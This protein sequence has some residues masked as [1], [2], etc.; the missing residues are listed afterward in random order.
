MMNR[1]AICIAALLGLSLLTATVIRA[2][3]EF[4]PK[5]DFKGSR[6]A[7]G[8]LDAEPDAASYSDSTFGVPEVKFRLNYQVAPDAKMTFRANLNNGIFSDVDY[9]YL[10]YSNALAKL[11]PSLKGSA[12]NPNIRLG[13]IKLDIGEETWGNNMVEAATI[14]PSSTNTGAYDEAIQFFQSLPK[15]KLGIPVKWS[16]SVSNGNS[17]SGT[18]NKNDK[19][20]CM[21]LGANPIKELYV[22]ASYYNSGELG[23][24][25][26]AMSYAGLTARPTNSTEWRRIITEIDLR[27]DIQPGKENRLEPTGPAFSDSKAFF[28]VAYGQFKDDGKDTV[29]PIL[30]VTDREGTYYFIDATYNATDKIYVAGRYSQVGFNKDTLLASLNKVT[31]NQFTRITTDIGYRMSDNTH[32]KAEYMTNSEDVAAGVTEPGN[33]QYSVILAVKF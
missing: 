10:D 8:Y 9:A 22:S 20:F 26:A 15:E 25:A 27:Y 3:D 31:C 4:K 16:L 33:N 21:K 17:I 24:G 23:T 32:I 30:T 29:A 2:E 5:M 19:A 13:K 11:I 14:N 1:R 6:I 28:R 12:F 18:D 7:V